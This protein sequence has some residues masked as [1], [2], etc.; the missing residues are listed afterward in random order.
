ME[1]L[2]AHNRRTQRVVQPL[3]IRRFGDELLLIAHCHLR[4][5][6]RT[7]KL[8]RIVQLT[9]LDAPPPPA[10]PTAAAALPAATGQPSLRSV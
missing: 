5:D 6:R 9:R 10:A 7:F 2:D 8:Q 1:Y 4:N 3:N